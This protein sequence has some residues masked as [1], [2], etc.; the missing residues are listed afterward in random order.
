M[1]WR[2][3]NASPPPWA[4]LRVKIPLR[5]GSEMVRR[6]R[7]RIATRTPG[8]KFASMPRRKTARN[9][10]WAWIRISPT[11]RRIRMRR[12]LKWCATATTRSSRRMKPAFPRTSYLS[13]CTISIAGTSTAT[14]R[15]KRRAWAI[16]LC[17]GRLI[18]AWGI[19]TTSN[20]TMR[21]FPNRRA[22]PAGRQRRTRAR[23]WTRP[24]PRSFAIAIGRAERPNL[25]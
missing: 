4:S 22:I 16:S 5:L 9:T 8:T 24:S 1:Q 12:W 15:L 23:S 11:S 3:K 13:S 21:T 7:R 20:A 17:A 14:M 19:A 10:R 2:G 25:C 18:K 6:P